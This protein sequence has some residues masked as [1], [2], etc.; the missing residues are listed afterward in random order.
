MAALTRASQLLFLGLSTRDFPNGLDIEGER[1]VNIPMSVETPT[2][3]PSSSNLH[4]AGWIDDR[5]DRIELG[6]VV[7]V[8]G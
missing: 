6:E 3:R 8:I 4:F 7:V 5:P 1:T 2:R